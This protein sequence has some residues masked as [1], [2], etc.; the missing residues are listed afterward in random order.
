MRRIQEILPSMQNARACRQYHP[1]EP[2]R[3]K[4]ECFWPWRAQ[5]RDGCQCCRSGWTC[6]CCFFQL[7]LSLREPA[8]SDVSQPSRSTL[9]RQ[10]SILQ[11]HMSRWL[12]AL[13]EKGK[14]RRADE[15]RSGIHM[16]ATQNM[17][18]WI[19]S[20][21]EGGQDSI[22]WLPIRVLQVRTLDFWQRFSSQVSTGHR[23][24]VRIL[25]A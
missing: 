1:C 14:F 16:E 19:I 4:W 23:S 9:L 22:P 5:G 12:Y 6:Q 13:T 21:M 11:Q 17:E 10:V 8:N 7:E 3:L 20:A 18:A 25:L 24:L 15:R 2:G